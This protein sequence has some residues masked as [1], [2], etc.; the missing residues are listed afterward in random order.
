MKSV[1]YISNL[2]YYFI[3]NK[4]QHKLMSLNLGIFILK[5]LHFSPEPNVCFERLLTIRFVFLWH[6]LASMYFIDFYKIISTS[7]CNF[8]MKIITSYTCSSR[9]KISFPF[10]E[11][12]HIKSTRVWLSPTW[13]SFSNLI[14]I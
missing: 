6:L 8:Y 14:H 2:N 3:L 9:P 5:K 10:Q 4:C 1:Q 11:S 13:I 7:L 12:F